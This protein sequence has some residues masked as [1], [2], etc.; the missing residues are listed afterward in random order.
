MENTFKIL[1][2]NCVNSNWIARWLAVKH[3]EHCECGFDCKIKVN[4]K[5]NGHSWDY[6]ITKR[7]FNVLNKELTLID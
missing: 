7:E 5:R 4:V 6:V 1:N 3:Q 2:K